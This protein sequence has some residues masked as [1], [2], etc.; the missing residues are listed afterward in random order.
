MR[1]DDEGEEPEDQHREDERLVTPERLARVVRD[2]LRDDAHAGQNEHVNFRM[3]E[4]PEQVLPEKRTATAADLQR[5]AVHDQ[6]ARHE[7]TGRRHAIHQLHDDRGFERR[8][9]EQQQK[10]GHELRPDEERQPHPGH[11]LGAQLNDRGD[12]IDRAKQRRGD[13]ENKADEPE[14]LA[15]ENQIDSSARCPR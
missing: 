5:R 3:P 9:R 7:E 6:A 2:D 1:P 10:R 13:Q 12:E 14:R 11:P 4:E 15:V 8:K